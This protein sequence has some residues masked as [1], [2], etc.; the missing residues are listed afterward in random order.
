MTTHSPASLEERIQQ[1]SPKREQYAVEVAEL[2]LKHAREVGAS[3]LHLLPEATQTHGVLLRIDGVLRRVATISQLGSNVVTRLKVLAELLTYRTDIPQEGRIRAA[4]NTA[5]MR[6]ST[7]PTLHGEKA[8]VRLFSDSGRYQKVEDLGL[9]AD[10]ESG[11]RR[12]IAKTSGVLLVSG[13]AGSG[14][15]TTLYACLRTILGDPLQPRS[16]STLEDPVE[17]VL[18]GVAQTTIQQGKELTYA[19]GLSSLMR[20]DPDVIL[21]GE[22]R[23][24][25]VAE[26]VF[27]AS[28]TGHL[29]LT[30]FHAGRCVDALGRLLDMR[31]E[32]YVIRS[33]LNGVLSQRLLRRTCE[34]RRAVNSQS[35]SNAGAC[36]VCRGSGYAGR[37]LL[38][39][40][41]VPD[42]PQVAEAILNRRD[43]K[44]LAETLQATGMVSFDERLQT[45]LSTGLTTREEAWRV[46]GG[47][48]PLG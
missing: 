25:V 48:M 5:E 33:G 37:L 32:P 8:V 3:D 14:K 13:P 1:I 31:I 28:L 41:L 16:I 46:F 21:V 29:V 19:R 20:Q 4:G 27:Q 34:C 43:T 30:S 17:C 6:V 22:I 11:L 18:P 45:L 36:D 44:A 10:L 47:E 38:A 2:L 35:E 9:P 7:F 12:L 40:L 42:D 23:D 15:T 26:T 24:H 39:E